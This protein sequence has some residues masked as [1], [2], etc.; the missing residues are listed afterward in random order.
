M[1]TERDVERSKAQTEFA[2]REGIR[3]LEDKAEELAG[4]PKGTL[5]IFNVING[6]YVTASNRLEA[7]DKFHQLFGDNN[8]LAFVHEVGGRVFIGGGLG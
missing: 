7:M 3:W 2:C 8:T 4:L 5:V 1:I 6:K